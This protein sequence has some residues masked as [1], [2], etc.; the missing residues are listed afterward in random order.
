[1]GEPGFYLFFHRC[2]TNN[3]GP[4]SLAATPHLP[5]IYHRAPEVLNLFCHSLLP[6]LS[7]YLPS[8]RTWFAPPLLPGMCLELSTNLRLWNR[9]VYWRKLF[10]RN[11][12]SKSILK[13]G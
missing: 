11:Q 5:H 7:R 10:F 4:R 6:M 12:R 3:K 13:Q 2:S 9:L 8:P 1:M